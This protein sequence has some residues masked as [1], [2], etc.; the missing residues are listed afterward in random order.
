MVNYRAFKLKSHSCRCFEKLLLTLAKI[1]LK[2]HSCAPVTVIMATGIISQ[3]LA[4]GILSQILA[5]GIL[6][7]ILAKDPFT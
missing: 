5:K 4:K 7:H 1:W 3:I 2:G 6:S